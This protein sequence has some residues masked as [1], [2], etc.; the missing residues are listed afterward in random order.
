MKNSFKYFN[1]FVEKIHD[2]TT[3]P[4]K[5]PLKMVSPTLDSKVSTLANTA[6]L[7]DKTRSVLSQNKINS[8]ET[9]L[10]SYRNN[11]VD[12]Q[13]TNTNDRYEETFRLRKELLDY[14]EKEKR[15][16]TKIHELER[17]NIRL[18]D[19]IKA[20]ER[21]YSEK[22]ALFLQ[23]KQEYQ[24]KYNEIKIN[25]E[26]NQQISTAREEK[27]Q[28]ALIVA[29]IIAELD[30]KLKEIEKNAFALAK[31]KKTN[32][33]ENVFMEE[34]FNKTNENLLKKCK[35]MEFVIFHLHNE[36]LFLKQYFS[37]LYSTQKANPEIIEKTQDSPL[38]SSLKILDLMKKISNKG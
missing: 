38:P 19:I 32:N 7:E 9:T 1:N 22:N 15:Y 13:K 23:E 27:Q 3:T 8:K 2:K 26:K 24:R 37:S 4:S 5:S 18:L 25:F 35:E 28:D 29:S 12:T 6:S 17:E 34:N 21:D 30:N 16:I 31:E 11:N 10:Q 20:N 33:K 14:K 36:N